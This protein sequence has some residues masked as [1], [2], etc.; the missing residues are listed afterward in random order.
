MSVLLCLLA[1]VVSETRGQIIVIPCSEHPCAAGV[2]GGTCQH[3]MHCT[4]SAHAYPCETPDDYVCKN[5][6]CGINCDPAIQ[7]CKCFSSLPPTP[8]PSPSPS[9]PP[10][11]SPIS[12]H[13]DDDDDGE[14]SGGGG[15]EEDDHDGEESGG[16][17]EEEG[18]D[19]D[20]EESGGKGGKSGD[21]ESDTEGSGG[22]GGKSGGEESDD[23]EMPTPSPA[24]SP[25]LIPSPCLDDPCRAF[26]ISCSKD[27][28][29]SKE[30]KTRGCDGR[31][32]PKARDYKCQHGICG[33]KKDCNSNKTLSNRCACLSS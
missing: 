2:L 12:D 13:S 10:S 33:V 1:F 29:C 5:G 8:Y 16:G 27:K 4:R 11:P 15:E 17:G 21:D 32:G 20:G 19:H 3:D 18:D 31:G 6:I 30:A 23:E 24:P 22:K 9:L 14:E 28:E 26:D 25:L 7:R